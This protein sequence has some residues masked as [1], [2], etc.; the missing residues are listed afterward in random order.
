[1]FVVEPTPRDDKVWTAK[2]VIDHGRDIYLQ[3][4]SGIGRR[5]GSAFILVQGEKTIPFEAEW[6]GRLDPFT[7]EPYFLMHFSMFGISGFAGWLF[8]IEPYEFADEAEKKD[9]MRIAA[10]GLVVHG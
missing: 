6:D 8:G 9:W 4:V 2:R 3:S 7:G 10:E 1:M 5:M